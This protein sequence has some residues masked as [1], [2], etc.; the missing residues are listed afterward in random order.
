LESSGDIAGVGG[1]GHIS[2]GGGVGSGC[3]F[4][5]GGKTIPTDGGSPSPSS[6]ATG[7]GGM[8]T[9]DDGRDGGGQ[10]PSVPVTRGVTAATTKRVERGKNRMVRFADQK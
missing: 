5:G 1:G 9:L 6:V 10:S 8:I 4:M 2:N 3:T 7:D